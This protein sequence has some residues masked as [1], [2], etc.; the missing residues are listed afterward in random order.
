MC[1]LSCKASGTGIDMMRGTAVIW[2]LILIGALLLAA[3][4]VLQT[5]ARCVTRVTYCRNTVRK[6]RIC[7]ARRGD[8]GMITTITYRQ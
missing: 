8:G 7:T 1:A 5:D 6:C 3:G 2:I 4:G